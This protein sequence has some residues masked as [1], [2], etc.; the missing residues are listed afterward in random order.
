LTSTWTFTPT[1][2][3]TATP[4]RTPTSTRT[5]S[6]TPTATFTRTPTNT[7]TP[8]ITPF[9]PGTFSPTPTPD[10]FLVLDRNFFD[11]TVQPLGMDV[12]VEAPGQVKVM[13]FNIGGEQVVKLM[14]QSQSVGNYRVYWDGLNKN[15]ALV[16][17]GLYFVIIETPTGRMIQKVIVLK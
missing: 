15:G 3:F 4:T 2:T 10:R 16:G 14:D 7:P 17:N 11:P 13:V 8:T 12:K 6:Y 5:P 9:P 1:P